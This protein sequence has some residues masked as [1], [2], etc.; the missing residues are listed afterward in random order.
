MTRNRRAILELERIEARAVIPPPSLERAFLA[1]E[2]LD[3][4]HPESRGQ[5]FGA[6]FH[7]ARH[8]QRSRTR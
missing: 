8:E 4:R 3:Q 6:M 5:T 7:P 1:I 2:Q